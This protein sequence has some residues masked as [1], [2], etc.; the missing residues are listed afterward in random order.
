MESYAVFL[1]L[2]VA[3]LRAWCS[4]CSCALSYCVGRFCAFAFAVGLRVLKHL[5]IVAVAV[6]THPCEYG[7]YAESIGRLVYFLQEGDASIA[8]KNREY[9]VRTDLKNAV[10]AL[11]I[12]LRLCNLLFFA[13]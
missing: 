3:A 10:L 9:T 7:D 1:P 4:V 5:L 12:F 6:D 8:G 11:V 13:G 2:P